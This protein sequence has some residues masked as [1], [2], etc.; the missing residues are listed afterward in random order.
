MLCL[1]SWSG[2]AG[3]PHRA[4]IDGFDVLGLSLH[5]L[6]APC[7]AT[8][9]GLS[10]SYLA[11]AILFVACSTGIWMWCFE[12]AL[13]AGLWAALR[14]SA[15]QPA[16]AGWTRRTSQTSKRTGRWESNYNSYLGLPHAVLSSRATKTTFLVF[17]WFKLQSGQSQW[18]VALWTESGGGLPQLH[19][20]LT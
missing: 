10:C 11:A 3:F 9:S 20:R 15:A 6:S 5:C 13:Y 1:T 2:R 19:W 16:A 8:I 14:G 17:S 18:T 4:H 7:K 12:L